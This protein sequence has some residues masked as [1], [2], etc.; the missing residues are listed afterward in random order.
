MASS[1]TETS[2]GEHK[3]R[4]WWLYTILG[5][6]FLFAGAFVITNLAFGSA[7][8]AIWVASAIVAA[9]AYQ[10]LQALRAWGHRGFVFDMLVGILYVAGGIILLLNPLQASMSLTLVLGVVWIMS[11]LGRV[12]L[13]GSM[14]KGRPAFVLSGAVSIVAGLVILLQWPGSGLRVL[15]LCLGADLIFH[16]I[17]WTVYSFLLLADSKPQRV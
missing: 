1:L 4:S 11:G 9:G 8:S 15:G 14:G 7:V 12:F 13:A 3:E 16:G 2:T 10:V 6:V 17:A 5:V